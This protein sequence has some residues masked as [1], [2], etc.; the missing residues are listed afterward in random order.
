MKIA[1]L[2]LAPHISPRKPE[3]IKGAELAINSLGNSVPSLPRLHRPRGVRLTAS[4]QFSQIPDQ[5]S[6][7]P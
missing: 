3:D 7:K 6:R 1:P 5:T 4:V 2:A